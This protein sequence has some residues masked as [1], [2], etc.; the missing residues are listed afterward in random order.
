MLTKG[1]RFGTVIPL[2]L[3]GISSFFAVVVAIYAMVVYAL[4]GS[5][6]E[7]WTSLAVIIGLGQGAILALLGM[8]W[9]RLDTLSKGLSRKKDVAADINIIP[10]SF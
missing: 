6:P 1:S 8:I 4:F 10:A 9:S 3:A 7:G 2:A 5:T